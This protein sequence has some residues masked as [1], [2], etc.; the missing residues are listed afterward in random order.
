MD[1]KK[2]TE[3]QKKLAE[4]AAE[5]SHLKRRVEDLEIS[6]KEARVA[7]ARRDGMIEGYREA[8]MVLSRGNGS[9]SAW[10]SILGGLRPPGY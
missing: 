8:M 6:A 9:P 2:K 5:N 1:D 3:D 7:A 4:L 10:G